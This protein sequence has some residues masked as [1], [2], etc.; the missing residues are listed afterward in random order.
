[1]LFWYL[2]VFAGI[3]L[4]YI[5]VLFHY[6]C[7]ESQ[8]NVVVVYRGTLKS[9]LT[10]I[11]SKKSYLIMVIASIMIIMMVSI[12]PISATVRISPTVPTTAILFIIVRS[13]ARVPTGF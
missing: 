1:M 5:V 8:Q 2:E 7:L 3:V 11:Q 4:I 10:S 13:F 12:V 6:P 9:R